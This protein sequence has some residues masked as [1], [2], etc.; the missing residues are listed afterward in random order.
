MLDSIRKF[1]IRK[2]LISEGLDSAYY[3]RVRLSERVPAL[4]VRSI[5]H[6]TVDKDYSGREQ[7][8][9]TVGPCSATHTRGVVHHDTAHHRTL[10]G[11]RVRAELAS[12]R[13][14]ELIDRRAH[15]SGLE[16]HCLPVI[17]SRHF[18]PVLSCN[19]Q[20]RIAYRLA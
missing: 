13:L 2:H 19:H 7:H 1:L 16:S 3:F 17:L 20:Y 5:Q 18:L 14:Q 8:P 9:V 4:R 12:V 15:D 11:S 6:R 10:D